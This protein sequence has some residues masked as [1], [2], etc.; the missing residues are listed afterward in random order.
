MQRVCSNMKGV[1]YCEG[2]SQIQKLQFQSRYLKFIITSQAIH[3]FSLSED[4][5]HEIRV[6]T[7]VHFKHLRERLEYTINMGPSFSLY[8]FT[9]I[10]YQ[11]YKMEYE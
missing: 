8:N 2:Q 5:F 11:E 10:L 4:L 1:Q 7:F 6:H 9:V 3:I